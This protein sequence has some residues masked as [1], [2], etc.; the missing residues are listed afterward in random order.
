M[1][2]RTKGPIFFA[3]ILLIFTNI[4]L[5][6]KLNIVL[7][8]AFCLF[9]G[10]TGYRW[11]NRRRTIKWLPPRLA[12]WGDAVFKRLIVCP[13]D[14]ILILGVIYLTVMRGVSGRSI[15]PADSSIDAQLAVFALT[16]LAFYITELGQRALESGYHGFRSLPELVINP[17][18]TQMRQRKAKATT[19]TAARLQDDTTVVNGIAVVEGAEGAGDDKSERQLDQEKRW[20][21]WI[22][23]ELYRLSGG[24]S[25]YDANQA[26]EPQVS[27]HA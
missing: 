4:I 16:V 22:N 10:I 13:Y 12:D 9:L 18:I 23:E 24:E 5:P 26:T 19:A 8:I 21:A 2:P 7:V 3:A 11:S 6:P 15:D 25:Y 20:Q 1:N 17:I 27:E 14:G